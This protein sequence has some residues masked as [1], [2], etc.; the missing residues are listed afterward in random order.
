MK[1]KRTTT[2][3]RTIRRKRAR[4]LPRVNAK[5]VRSIVRKEIHKDREV[6]FNFH[7]TANATSSNASL[8]ETHS[9]LSQVQQGLQVENRIGDEIK[10]IGLSSK[11]TFTNTSNN[12]L[13][14]RLFFVWEYMEMAAQG[15][16]S[17]NPYLFTD[18]NNLDIIWTTASGSPG[19]INYP[20]NKKNFKVIY[21]RTIKL[22]KAN[23]T[24]GG[25]TK[26][27]VFFKKLNQKVKYSD[28]QVGVQK[29][30]HMLCRGICAYSPN[31]LLTTTTFTYSYS[32][33]TRFYYV[34]P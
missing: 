30:D 15:M 29:Q 17:G 4:K 11:H 14:I 31:S 28:A 21:D 10:A 13:Y 34:D 5:A 1:R 22:A 24:G 26:R 8:F 27:I 2:R 25:D 3:K 16:G 33:M 32:E 20:L 12:V 6:K 9:D 18:A 23:E 7:N 19:L